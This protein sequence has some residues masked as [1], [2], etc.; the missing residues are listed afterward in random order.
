MWSKVLGSI[1]VD[2]RPREVGVMTKVDAEPLV[3]ISFSLGFRAARLKFSDAVFE[4]GNMFELTLAGVTRC[5][6]VASSLDGGLVAR[7]V[8]G[9]GRKRTLSTT[10]LDASHSRVRMTR[11]RLVSNR[12]FATVLDN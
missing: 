1:F 8:D 9:D 4:G 5:H 6:C 2:S 12:G 7:I 11:R 3:F 10:R